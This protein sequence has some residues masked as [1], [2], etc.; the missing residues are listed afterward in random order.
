MLGAKLC[1]RFAAAKHE[2]SASGGAFD[3]KCK[4]SVPR[5]VACS[6]ARWSSCR[7]AGA[8][9]CA[10]AHTICTSLYSRRAG[11]GPPGGVLRSQTSAGAPTA[12]RRTVGLASSILSTA[13]SSTARQQKAPVLPPM[14]T[15]VLS[16]A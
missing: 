15:T 4:P 7:Y 9:L 5:S 13:W 16:Q 8:H 1:A 11:Q 2:P 14:L 12:W 3:A 10:R 6:E